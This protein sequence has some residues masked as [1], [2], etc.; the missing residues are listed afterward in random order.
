MKPLRLASALLAALTVSVGSYA[1][2]DTS[3]M[4]ERMTA[5]RDKAISREAGG[6]YYSA[7]TSLTE[8]AAL[9]SALADTGLVSRAEASIAAGYAEYLE[10]EPRLYLADSTGAGIAVGSDGMSVAGSS[11]VKLNVPFELAD[12]KDFFSLIPSSSEETYILVE[13]DVKSEKDLRRIAFDMAEDYLIKNLRQL[14]TLEGK[15]CLSFCPSVAT[16]TAT[17]T[18]ADSYKLAFAHVAELADRYAPNVSMVYSLEDAR[19]PSEQTE[20]LFYPGDWCVDILGIELYH[21]E[22]DSDMTHAEAAYRCRGDCYDPVLSVKRLAESFIS[23]TGRD[24]IPVIITGCSF[25]WDGKAALDNWAEEAERFYRL[26][27]AACPNLE[28]VFY[29]NASS[30]M[31]IC[32]LRQNSRAAEVY[33]QCISLPWYDLR[34]R[35]DVSLSPATEITYIP[36]GEEVQAVL[37]VGGLFR[38]AEYS[39]YL[40]GSEVASGSPIFSVGEHTLTVYVTDERC[41]ARLDYTLSISDSGEASVTAS[42]GEHDLN[43]NGITDFGDIEIITTYIAGWRDYTGDEKSLDINGDGKIS[44]ADVTALCKVLS[45][46]L[47]E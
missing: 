46:E 44:L 37:Y 11:A 47:T 34:S 3:V 40:D 35:D 21:T 38:D 16:F 31:G 4:L 10:F 45:P 24:D 27:P 1:A 7:Y 19:T 43:Q 2:D 13:L 8:Y 39:L 28:A 9:A 29:S 22:T 14:S 20:M 25:P 15:V 23:A 41:N 42:V 30:S 17:R 18:L 33:K 26:I 5:A 32:N 36:L 6:Y 12:A